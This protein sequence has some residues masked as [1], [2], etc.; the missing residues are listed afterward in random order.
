MRGLFENPPV[1]L[2]GWRTGRASSMELRASS[3]SDANRRRRRLFEARRSRSARPRLDLA[4]SAP[5]PGPVGRHFP[6]RVALWLCG[7]GIGVAACSTAGESQN[8]DPSVDPNADTSAAPPTQRGID[9]DQGGAGTGGNANAPQSEG[10]PPE[11][12]GASGRDGRDDGTPSPPPVNSEEEIPLM[13][14]SLGDANVG[15]LVG[16]DCG[17]N[18]QCQSGVCW[19]YA[20]ID[21]TCVGRMCSMPCGEDAQCV[22]AAREIQQRR[23][24]NGS[25]FKPTGVSTRV[26]AMFAIFRSFSATLPVSR[27]GLPVSHLVDGRPT[28]RR[29]VGVFWRYGLEVALVACSQGGASGT[30]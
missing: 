28:S 13:E 15:G 20:D 14:Q 17:A 10:G 6:L 8:G 12:G 1:V 27:S 5:H 3:L 11:G 23:A 16:D 7:C 22:E 24:A 2:G 21:P 29:A 25:F 18:D 30:V 9:D 19:D 26:V 4:A